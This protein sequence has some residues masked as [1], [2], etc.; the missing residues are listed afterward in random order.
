M[1]GS[2]VIVCCNLII[3]IKSKH[4][5]SIRT[6][7]QYTISSSELLKV[8]KIIDVNIRGS[9]A[10]LLR[11]PFHW[12]NFPVQWSISNSYRPCVVTA[13]RLRTAKSGPETRVC[14]SCESGAAQ[15]S[16]LSASRCVRHAR[17]RVCSQHALHMRLLRVMRVRFQ[18]ALLSLLL[19]RSCLMRHGER[20]ASDFSAP[21]CRWCC[22]PRL[23]R[24]LTKNGR[25]CGECAAL[26]SEWQISILPMSERLSYRST[27]R[28]IIVCCRQPQ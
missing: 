16:L 18:R 3:R 21:C 4:N 5:H 11:P 17:L 7:S 6:Q 19:C 14:S 1:K 9:S 13:T 28:I 26:H 10:R 23:R 22:W 27:S 8:Y 25:H 2:K 20:C 24:W 15:H 12:G